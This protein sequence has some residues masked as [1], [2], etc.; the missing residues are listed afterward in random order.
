MV[1]ALTK[2]VWLWP[3]V[4]TPPRPNK[5]NKS[6]RLDN[7]PNPGLQRHC[8]SDPAPRPHIDEAETARMGTIVGFEAWSSNLLLCS[9]AAK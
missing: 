9:P 8:A 3:F 7:P 2:R 6:L 1:S 4:T 5:S